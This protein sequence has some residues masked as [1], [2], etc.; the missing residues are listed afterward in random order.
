M[1]PRESV[2]IFATAMEEKLRRDEVKGG[3]ENGVG[4]DYL[5]HRA[6]DEMTELYEALREYKANPTSGGRKNIMQECADVANFCMMISS[7]FHPVAKELK[8]GRRE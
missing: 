3:W 8:R 1:E 7:L 2:V 6:G 5:W 4:V